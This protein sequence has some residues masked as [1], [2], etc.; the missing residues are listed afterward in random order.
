MSSELI[1]SSVPVQV[2]HTKTG[3]NP[4]TIPSVVDQSLLATASF[5]DR[6]VKAAHKVYE[7]LIA[8]WVPGIIEAAYDLSVFAELAKGPGDAVSL[9]H[10]LQCDIRGM[11]ILL[12]ALYALGLIGRRQGPDDSQLYRL[13]QELQHCLLPGEMY[14]LAGKIMYDRR[15]AWDA[16]HNF[17]T[18]VRTGSVDQSG[19]YRQNQISDSDYEYLVSGI[20]FWAP[21]CINELCRGLQTLEWD[22]RRAA[23]V[24]D[25]GCGT[26]LYSQLLLQHFRHWTAVGLDCE[27]IAPLARA[28]SIQLNVDS[29]FTCR[30]SDF[31][32]DDWGNNYDLMLFANIFHLQHNESAQRLLSIASRSLAPDGLICIVDHILDNERSVHSS[33]DRFALLFAASMLATGGGDAYSL[34]DYDRWF[35]QAGLQRLCVLDT[36]MHRLLI[37]SRT[38]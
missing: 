26:G 2:V 34:G 37:A 22:T 33:Q 28:Q 25:V 30:V 15:L 6:T 4:H 32:Q 24:L 1:G 10:T 7:H 27:R 23:S 19:H 29:R 21:P 17:A 3:Q 13:P 38:F 11:R 35:E 14:S 5:D 16:W 8:L 18:A 9:A 20:N 31:W 12:D 36:P